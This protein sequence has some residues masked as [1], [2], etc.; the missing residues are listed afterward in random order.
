[1][2]LSLIHILK[3]VSY[4]DTDHDYIGWEL[5]DADQSVWSF[6]KYGILRYVTDVNGF[7]TVLDYDVIDPKGFLATVAENKL[8][9]SN[10]VVFFEGVIANIFVNI[11][12]P[13]SYTH[14]DVYKR[15]MHVQRTH[16]SSLR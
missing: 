4:K 10:Q 3:A 7:K 16:H 9:R 15:Q 5:T 14:L 6:D 8:Q 11:A 1:M 2:T 12:I 13:V